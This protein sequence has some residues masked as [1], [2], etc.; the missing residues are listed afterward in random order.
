MPRNIPQ[1]IKRHEEVPKG[2]PSS[3]ITQ[4]TPHKKTISKYFQ[5]TLQLQNN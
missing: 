1:T 3:L 2:K 5:E 4:K